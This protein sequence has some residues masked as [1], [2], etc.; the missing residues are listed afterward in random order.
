MKNFFGLFIAVFL[1]LPVTAEGSSR[2]KLDL[3]IY[4]YENGKYQ[5]AVDSIKALLPKIEDPLVQAEAY[6]Y[7]AFSYVMLD[8]VNQAKTN[9]DSLLVKFPKAEIDTVSVPPNI[10]VVFK[11]SKLERQLEEGKAL[12]KKRSKRRMIWIIGGTSV[13]AAAVGTTVYFIT[14]APEEEPPPEDL[15]KGDIRFKW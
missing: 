12:E 13:A 1:F 14:R 9:F 10:T 15:G 3:C 8:M 6:K 4:L 5:E 11:Q 7:L 2:S